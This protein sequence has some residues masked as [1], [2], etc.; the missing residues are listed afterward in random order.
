M[1]FRDWPGY[2]HA[3]DAV[4]TPRTEGQ[5]HQWPHPVAVWIEKP[6]KT[7]CGASQPSNVQ[8][9]SPRRRTRPSLCL[10]CALALCVAVCGCATTDQGATDDPADGIEGVIDPVTERPV[11]HVL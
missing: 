10:A 2:D 11:Q 4:E 7:P 9:P 8:T 6:R 1:S 3:F 5:L